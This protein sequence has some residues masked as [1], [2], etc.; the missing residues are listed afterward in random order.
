MGGQN[1]INQS[2][3]GYERMTVWF[4]RARVWASGIELREDSDEE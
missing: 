2:P 4:Q 3:A 1:V